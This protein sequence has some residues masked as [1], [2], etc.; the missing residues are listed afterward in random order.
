M[1]TADVV[2]GATPSLSTC[3]S[4]LSS[5]R[6]LGLSFRMLLPWSIDGL[7][8]EFGT[9]DDA[10][11]FINLHY[12]GFFGIDAE[13]GRWLSDPLTPAKKRFLSSS[14]VFLLKDEQELVGIM[15]G[16]PADWQRYYIRTLSLLPK[17]RGRS[18]VPRLFA[19]LGNAL[20]S[21]GVST[22]EGDVSP[23]NVANVLTQTKL[24]AVVTG[25]T[26]TVRWGSLL[27]FTIFLDPDADAVFRRQYCAGQMERCRSSVAD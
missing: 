3:A 17:Y 26:H 27:H 7:S 6:W 8:V 5:E 19:R 13:D 14:D 2:Q 21:A 22:L 11:A 20:K 18:L 15:I 23:V 4:G 16:E 1:K 12:T 9:L 10:L 25:T 24:G